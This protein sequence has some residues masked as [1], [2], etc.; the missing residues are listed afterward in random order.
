MSL[1]A[2]GQWLDHVTD[3]QFVAGSSDSSPRPRAVAQLRSFG[4]NL[5]LLPNF[6]L[7]QCLSNVTIE[8]VVPSV[9]CLCQGK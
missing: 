4:N 9:R 6:G 5:F 8:A 3:D 7:C 2:V 1:V